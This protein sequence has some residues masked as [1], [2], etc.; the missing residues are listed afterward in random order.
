MKS[1]GGKLEFWNVPETLLLPAEE[2]AAWNASEILKE[3][4]LFFALLCKDLVRE[5]LWLMTFLFAQKSLKVYLLG[6]TEWEIEGFVLLKWNSLSINETQWAEFCGDVAAMGRIT[7]IVEPHSY[8]QVLACCTS[9]FHPPRPS[10]FHMLWNITNSF[11]LGSRCLF[12]IVYH[13]LGQPIKP[14]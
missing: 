13:L 8:A 5:R 1:S 9:V 10:L 4:R 3:E 7:P 12:L 14:K 11:F 2:A 6:S